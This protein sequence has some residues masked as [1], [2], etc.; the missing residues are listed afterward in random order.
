[1]ATNEQKNY[2]LLV[3]KTSRNREDHT[4]E[5]RMWDKTVGTKSFQGMLTNE[6]ISDLSMSNMT[7]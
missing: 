1:M 6:F 2:S 7:Y 5:R 3:M 4:P